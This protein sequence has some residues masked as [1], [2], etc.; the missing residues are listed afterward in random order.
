[1]SDDGDR[2][3]EKMD[4]NS[5]RVLGGCEVTYLVFMGR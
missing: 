4:V 1:M 5:L 3:E 2:K